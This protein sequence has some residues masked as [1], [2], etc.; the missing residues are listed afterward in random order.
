MKTFVPKI[1]SSARKWWVVDLNGVILGRAAGRV[2]SILRGKDKVIFTP[3]LDTGDHVVAIN[4][5]GLRVTGKSKPTGMKYYRYTGY[6]GGLRQTT[7]ANKM[8]TN[9]DDVFRTA[10]RRMLPKNRLGR[11]VI[12]KLHVYADAGHPHM[13]QKPEELRLK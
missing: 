13:A 12:K 8:R 6:P 5:G 1:D 10:V 7:L 3:H 2:A 9:P 11:K 4:A